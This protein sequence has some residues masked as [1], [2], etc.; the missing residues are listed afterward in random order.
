MVAKNVLRIARK[1]VGI[2]GNWRRRWGLSLAIAASAG[3]AILVAVHDTGQFQLDGDAST[4]AQTVPTPPGLDAWDKVCNEATGGGIAGCGTTAVTSG[5]TAVAWTTDNLQNTTT[6]SNNATIFTGGGSKD[7]QDVNQWA[8]KDG[9]GGLPDKDNL[10]H[11]FAARYKLPPSA[12]CPS[13]GA[14][15]CDVIFFGSDRL[16]NSGDAQQGFWFFQMP[17]GLDA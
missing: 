3:V 12:T 4:A 15:T 14:P 7:P 16:D 2:S 9:A 6:P 11:A 17:I 1:I 13:G 8:W 5:A 10:Q